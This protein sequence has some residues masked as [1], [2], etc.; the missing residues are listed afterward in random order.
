MGWTPRFGR[1]QPKRRCPFFF[2]NSG[3]PWGRGGG[4]KNYFCFLLSY[5]LPPHPKINVHPLIVNWATCMCTLEVV[6]LKLTA[7]I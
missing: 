5:F 6:D 7:Y 3:P 2:L 4:V 1:P